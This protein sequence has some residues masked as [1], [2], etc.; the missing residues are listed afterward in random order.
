MPGAKAYQKRHAKKWKSL[1]DKGTNY[2]GTQLNHHEQCRRT[3]GPRHRLRPG[4]RYSIHMSK[5]VLPSGPTA[6]SICRVARPFPKI[7]RDFFTP[8]QETHNPRSICRHGEAAY[9][10]GESHRDYTSIN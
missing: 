1:G 2:Q 4:H 5:A 10:R 8:T 9:A 7:S 6:L 3:L